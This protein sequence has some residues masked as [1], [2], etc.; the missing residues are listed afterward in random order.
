MSRAPVLQTD[1]LTLRGQQASD[2]EAFAA[3]WGYPDVTR[4]IGGKP[5]TREEAWNRLLRNIGHWEEMGFGPWM[6]CDRQTGQLLGDVGFC[7]FQRSMDPPFGDTPEIGWVM[8]PAAHGK[9]L[10]GEAVAAALAWAD[11][12]FEGPRTVC[13]IN[14]ANTPSMRLAARMG[15][16]EF[17]RAQYHGEIVQLERWRA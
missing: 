8:S 1:R 7:N 15:F 16:K 12:N 13:I 5:A 14:P 9:G 17:A 11:A 10:A 3:M 2:F 4:F 6:V